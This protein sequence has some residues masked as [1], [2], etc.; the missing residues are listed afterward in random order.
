[1]RDN[2]KISI[3]ERG[4]QVIGYID[5]SCKFNALKIDMNIDNENYPPMFSVAN[6]FRRAAM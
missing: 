3:K 4:G 1:M 5:P 2:K 6:S